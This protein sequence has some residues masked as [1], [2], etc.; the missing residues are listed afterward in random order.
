MKERSSAE[1]SSADLDQTGTSRAMDV[2]V[3]TASQASLLANWSFGDLQ[4]VKILHLVTEK[5]RMGVDPLLRR[6]GWVDRWA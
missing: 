3:E 1:R 6:Q 5:A 2:V 4:V